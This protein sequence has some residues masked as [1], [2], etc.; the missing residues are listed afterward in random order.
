MASHLTRGL[1]IMLHFPST[2]LKDKAYTMYHISALCSASKSL[3]VSQHLSQI[4]PEVAHLGL[5]KGDGVSSTWALPTGGGGG[6]Y[7][8]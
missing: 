1:N 7:V 2:I 8:Y 4:S 5:W 6:K 3:N